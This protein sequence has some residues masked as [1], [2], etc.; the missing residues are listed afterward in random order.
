[1][2]RQLTPL[3]LVVV[4][5][6]SPVA[7]E[8]CAIWCAEAA[9]TRQAHH[10]SSDSM[11][12]HL[13]PGQMTHHEMAV[14]NEKGNT[15][16]GTEAAPRHHHDTGVIAVGH[17]ASAGS[18]CGLTASAAPPC[19]GNANESLTVSSA[20]A[21]IALDPPA[22][23]PSAPDVTDP[24]GVPATVATTRVVLPPIPLVLRT[25]LRV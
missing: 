10:G 21:K 8:L 4:M 11:S 13:M 5:G 24:G 16:I 25:P 18:C 7:H 3:V 23:T 6:A 17:S 1:M 20:A 12:E 19:C 15:E 2:V 14:G 22:I 9:S